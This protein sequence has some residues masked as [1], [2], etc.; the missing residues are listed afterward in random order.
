LGEET[1]LYVDILCDGYYSED[2]ADQLIK[3]SPHALT[4]DDLATKNHPKEPSTAPPKEK[5]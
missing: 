2:E 1:E 5:R 3:S 4:E